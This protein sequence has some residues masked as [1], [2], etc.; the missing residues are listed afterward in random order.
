VSLLLGFSVSELRDPAAR[1]LTNEI[2][3]HREL[4]ALETALK[5]HGSRL[6]DL[7]VGISVGNEDVHRYNTGASL[8]ASATMI[9]KNVQTVRNAIADPGK[10][11][12][13]SRWLTET[14]IGHSDTADLVLDVAEGQNFDFVGLNLH[15]YWNNEPIEV[16]KESYLGGLKNIIA[17]AKDVAG[18]KK[19]EVWITEVGW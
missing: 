2:K 11:P 16:A 8:G 15:P 5:G 14:P 6:A 9:R 4:E 19:P 1:V 3:L 17:R 7:I 10:W 13:I 12:H 18:D